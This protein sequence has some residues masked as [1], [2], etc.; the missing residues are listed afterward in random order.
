MKLMRTAILVTLI[1]LCLAPAC[2]FELDRAADE[3]EEVTGRQ[4]R[5]RD[6]GWWGV[7]PADPSDGED[8]EWSYK[9]VYSDV[10][11]SPD[12]KLLL[13]MTP[14]PGPDN[15]WD[16]PGLV[17]VV[18]RLPAGR[19]FV[20]P[21]LMNLKRINFSP[22]GAFAYALHEDGK[23]VS[24]LDLTLMQSQLIGAFDAPFSVLDV[25]PDGRF[26]IGSNL[27]TNDW[28]EYFAIF[29]MDCDP[30][31]LPS[32]HS[33]CQLGV[34]DTATGDSRVRDLPQPLRDLDYSPVHAGEALLTSWT[35]DA[36]GMPEATL[37]FLDIE[38]DQLVTAV[39]FPNCA[40]ELKLQPGGKLALL[41]PTIC[42]TRQEAS[43]DPIS[44]LDLEART[45]I[46]NLPGFGPV[47]ISADGSRAVGFTRQGDMAAQ[48]DYEQEAKVGL[49]V[50]KLPSLAWKVIDYGDQEPNYLLTGET[51]RFLYTHH[52]SGTKCWWDDN[53]DWRCEP[54]EDGLSL[55]DLETSSRIEVEGPEAGL[56][57]FVLANDGQ[58]L[59][60]LDNGTLVRL[61]VGSAVAQPMPL[62]P[63]PDL[64]NI[65]P[66]N[67]FLVMGMNDSPS[68]FFVPVDVDPQVPMT[69][70]S[71]D[72]A[73]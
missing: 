52:T 21:E 56:D 8:P 20:I 47:D 46:T 36:D 66:Q 69:F 17:L 9:L 1:A 55:F 73:F 27:P 22:D 41:A 2:N 50:V 45:F 31:F 32:D 58:T 42:R 15:G 35:W 62:S 59:F 37:A 12:G 64:M 7:D 26:L 14:V 53:G 19:R 67:D 72:L 24:R 3:N 49:I 44:V 48:W 23:T 33:R 71:M 70:Q 10:I 63:A 16:E 28:T 57:R 60:L 4:D 54:A 65:R 43:A 29:D 25:S 61:E 39:H 13:A 34:I 18:Q 51:G 5:G 40:D 38:S 68:F 6:P 11:L 30:P